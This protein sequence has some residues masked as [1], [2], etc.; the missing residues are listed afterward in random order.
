VLKTSEECSEL[1]IELHHYIK[2]ANIQAGRRETVAK[3]GSEIVDVMLTMHAASVRFG[4]IMHE[5]PQKLVLEINEEIRSGGVWGMSAGVMESS[6]QLM[7]LAKLLLQRVTKNG[8]MVGE[9]P[10]PEIPSQFME[11][12]CHLYKLCIIFFITAPWLEREAESKL[13]KLSELN[14]SIAG[15]GTIKSQ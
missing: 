4:I 7:R 6:M 13:T 14:K 5:I 8:E 1:S 3:V 12:Q 11:V 10:A 2:H 9:G 15:F